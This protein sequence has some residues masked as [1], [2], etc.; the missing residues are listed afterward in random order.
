[1]EPKET[2][3]ERF[4]G[5]IEQSAFGSSCPITGHS[6][7]TVLWESGRLSNRNPQTCQNWHLGVASH[8]H[9]RRLDYVDDNQR[10]VILLFQRGMLPKAYRG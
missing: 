9:S 5:P 10:D 1:M 4:A 6:S 2:C 3:L 7:L 8:W